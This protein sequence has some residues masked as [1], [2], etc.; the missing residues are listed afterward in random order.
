MPVVESAFNL[1]FELGL[2][3]E[4]EA[5]NKAAEPVVHAEALVHADALDARPDAGSPRSVASLK[6]GEAHTTL[7]DGTQKAPGDSDKSETQPRAKGPKGRGRAKTGVPSPKAKAKGKGEVPSPKAKAKAKAEPERAA[8]SPQAPS[9]RT[10]KRVRTF[11]KWYK[12]HK[13]EEAAKALAKAKAKARAQTGKP[14]AKDSK[15]PPAK[16]STEPAKDSTDAGSQ[17]RPTKAQMNRA[18]KAS[19]KAKL[20]QLAVARAAATKAKAAAKAKAK[21]K[22]APKNGTGPQAPIKAKA[23]AKPKAEPPAKK[24]KTDQPTDLKQALGDAADKIPGKELTKEERRA[25]LMRF[26]RARDTDPKN[27]RKEPMPQEIKDELKANPENADLI[28]NLWVKHKEDFAKAHAVFTHIRRKTERQVAQER[29][30][31]WAQIVKW[32]GDDEET[33]QAIIDGLPEDHKR[34]N[35]KALKCDKAVQY[36][37]LLE[38]GRDDLD[39]DIVES[40]IKGQADVPKEGNEEFLKKAFSHEPSSSSSARGPARGPA[41]GSGVIPQR[42]ETEAERLEREQKK[43]EALARAEAKKLALEKDIPQRAQ[44]WLKHINSDIGK[45][46]TAIAETKKVVSKEVGATY[47]NKFMASQQALFKLRTAFEKNLGAVDKKTIKE[48]EASVK[49]MKTDLQ[50]W[51]KIKQFYLKE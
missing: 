22:V 17:K 4:A 47:K 49:V 21:P 43:A 14:S 15:E 10:A 6:P 35:P 41:S 39:E 45:L 12:K 31:T 34:R 24:P 29:W 13:E 37:V 44:N 3:M 36:W 30:R 46:Q 26:I 2:V 40:G 19:A 42:V 23:A 33:A 20:A 38:D 5:S 9:P 32:Y 11:G 51:V 16:V 27:P 18:M 1:D 48:A 7:Q 8:P 28:F 25:A 50:A